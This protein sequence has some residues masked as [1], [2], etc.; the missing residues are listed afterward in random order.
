MEGLPKTQRSAVKRT[1]LTLGCGGAGFLGSLAVVHSPGAPA[2]LAVG[3]VAA[4]LSN[5]VAELSA[6]LPAIIAAL[7]AKRV[8]C[9]K[10]K[11]G[12]KVELEGARRRTILVNAGLEGKLDA[13]NLLRLLMIDDQMRARPRLSGEMLR[14]LLPGPRVPYEGDS[15]LAFIRA[16]KPGPTARHLKQDS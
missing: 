8:A 13:V 7:S 14:E 16:R 15:G 1:C 9:I 6:A 12:A 3:A 11:A 4:V 10:A 5:V 2:A